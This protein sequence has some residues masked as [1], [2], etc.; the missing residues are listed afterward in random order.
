MS[1]QD[2]P[3]QRQ[4]AGRNVASG[5]LLTGHLWKPPNPQ[6]LQATAVLG[7]LGIRSLIPKRI[8]FFLASHR[9][10]FRKGPSSNQPESTAPFIWTRD[11]MKRAAA[12]M[13]SYCNS[14]HPSRMASAERCCG[15]PACPEQGPCRAGREATGLSTRWELPFLRFHNMKVTHRVST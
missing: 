4:A 2:E 6:L 1:G 14:G 10:L 8:L 11:V 12:A 13:F 7:K 9:L 5:Q 3:G 15:L